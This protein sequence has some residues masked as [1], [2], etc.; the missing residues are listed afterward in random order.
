MLFFFILKTLARKCFVFLSKK[1]KENW[2]PDELTGIPAGKQH[3]KTKEKEKIISAQCV[4]LS[5]KYLIK[6]KGSERNTYYF[7]YVGLWHQ[8]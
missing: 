4:I 5:L 6:Y 8:K 7:Y 1:Q 3:V 2:D